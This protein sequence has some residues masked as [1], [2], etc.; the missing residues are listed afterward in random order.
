MKLHT[1]ETLRRTSEQREADLSRY[2]HDYSA[3]RGRTITFVMARPMRSARAVADMLRLPRL[4]ATAVSGT[5]EG[6][7]IDRALAQRHTRR[8]YFPHASVLIL[9]DDPEGYTRGPGKQ[10]VRR[11]VRKADRAGITVRRVSEPHEQLR[12]IGAAD[13]WERVNPN[14]AYRDTLAFNADCLRYRF[15]LVAYSAERPPTRACS[16]PGGWGLGPA[17]LFSHH[18]L[19]PR[20]EPGAVQPDANTC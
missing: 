14:P 1:P 4:T 10:T 12:L 13:Q 3:R 9:P 17:A 7:I 2:L 15:W 16:D 19:R 11:M 8:R 5:V 18:R 20:A 6:M